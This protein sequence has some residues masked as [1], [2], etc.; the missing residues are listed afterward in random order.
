MH[1]CQ[2]ERNVICYLY[3]YILW[4]EVDEK[5]LENLILGGG[6]GLKPSSS[7]CFEQ[8][9]NVKLGA[10]KG[11]F[12]LAEVLIT[13]GII[14]VVAALTLP[15]LIQKYQD[16]VLENQLKKTYSTLSQGIQKAMADDGVSNFGDTELYQSCM[17][18]EEK[19]DAC[20]QMVKKY[21]NVVAVKTTQRE[22]YKNVIQTKYGGYINGVDWTEGREVLGYY[23]DKSNR[24]TIP[25]GEGILLTYVLAD[26]S[27][28]KLIFYSDGDA[29]F[30]VDTNGEKG[31]NTEDLDVFLLSVD[32]DAR[33]QNYYLKAIQKN[34][35]KF[36]W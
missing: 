8:Y 13:L 20:I 21:F 19:S 35:W 25:I 36:P 12:T 23:R 14:G 1:T 24:W 33:F 28:F 3:R 6:N 27:E 5:V 9:S 34:N 18:P 30:Y 16:Q 31:P 17:Y 22:Y 26:G 29:R 10:R 11:A 15:S 4:R 7:A 2:H 32:G